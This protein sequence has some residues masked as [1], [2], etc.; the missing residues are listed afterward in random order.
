MGWTVSAHEASGIFDNTIESACGSEDFHNQFITKAQV[1]E[2][3]ERGD[4]LKKKKQTYCDTNFHG[5]KF[6]GCYE[7]K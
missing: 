7:I 4:L 5:D 6:L 1:K 2:A 3:I